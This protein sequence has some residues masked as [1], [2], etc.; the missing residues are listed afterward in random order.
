M[1][2]DILRFKNSVGQALGGLKVYTQLIKYK[3]GP[4]ISQ[5]YK[6]VFEAYEIPK[7]PLMTSAFYYMSTTNSVPNLQLDVPWL[8]TK[9]DDVKIGNKA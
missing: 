3:T 8:R 7:V 1:H 2:K 4:Q 9:K 6:F 5:N